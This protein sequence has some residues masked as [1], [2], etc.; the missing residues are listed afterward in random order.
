MIYFKTE[1]YNIKNIYKY[2]SEQMFMLNAY[3]N[4]SFKL[5]ILLLIIRCTLFMI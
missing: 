4:F 3:L 1:K 2:K 5:V